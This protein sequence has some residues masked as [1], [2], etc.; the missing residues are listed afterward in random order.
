MKNVA[1]F[2]A[3][4]VLVGMA[5]ATASAAE[6]NMR[7][8]T[9]VKAPHPYLD[10]AAYFKKE[11]EAQ[12]K[13]R[14]SIKIFSGGSLGK[15]PAVIGELGLGTVDLMVSGTNNAIK[16]VPEYGVFSLP[17]L[18]KSFDGLMNAVGPGSDVVKY[19]EGVYAKRKLGLKLLALGGS[20]T[21][22]LSN[23]KKP[24]HKLADIKGFKMRTPPSPVIAETWKTLGALPVTIAWTELY[25]GIQT[26]VAQALESSIPGYKGSK[27]YEVAPFLALTAHTIQVNHVT[28]S[29]KSWNKIPADLQMLLAKLAIEATA[30]GVEK[31]K[32]YDANLVSVLEKDHGVKVTRPDISEFRKVLI[33]VQDKFAKSKKLTEVLAMIRAAQ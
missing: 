20:G 31:A 6:F 3:A 7:M 24:I 8:H 22:N 12:S 28:M 21:R 9:L 16:Q 29:E 10:I 13:G 1:K 19:Y 15:D 5:S 33:P 27:L 32:G 25:A 18:F 2:T 23:S 4:V 14:I 30:H 26:G 11:V 17:Y